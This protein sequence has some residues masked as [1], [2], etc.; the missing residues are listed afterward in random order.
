[1]RVAKTVPRRAVRNTAI[2]VVVVAVVAT[3][4]FCISRADKSNNLS[5]RANEMQSM[6]I[7]DYIEESELADQYGGRGGGNIDVDAVASMDYEDDFD[8][9]PIAIP[10]EW[11]FSECTSTPGGTTWTYKSDDDASECAKA[12][13]ESLEQSGATLMESGFLDVSGNAWGC[14]ADMN[15]GSSS[16]MVTMIPQSSIEDETQLVIRVVVLDASDISQSMLS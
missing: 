11:A 2:A 10:I 15:D 6:L 4:W 12:V 5:E 16:V 7:E 13:L 9:M 8:G 14:A 1:M 3:A